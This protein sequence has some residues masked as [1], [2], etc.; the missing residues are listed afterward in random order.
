MKQL[1]ILTFIAILISIFT[2]FGC[3]DEV[4]INQ[5]IDDFKSAVN[6]NNLEGFSCKS[7]EIWSE[8]T[9]QRWII[10]TRLKPLCACAALIVA[11][12]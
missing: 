5:T 9:G 10:L 7:L 12:K 3:S 8:Y 2:I 11:Y 1:P 4:I 6:S